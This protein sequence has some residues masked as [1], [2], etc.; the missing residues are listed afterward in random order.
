M[1]ITNRV[2]I[3]RP[4]PDVFAAWSE[5]ERIPEWYVDSIERRKMSEGPVGVGT[6]YHAV[7]KVPPG[8]RV[9]GTLEV[10]RFEPPSLMSASLSAPYNATWEVTFDEVE[11]STRMTMHVVADLSGIQALAAPLVSRWADR[12]QQRGLE[13]FK[14][15][16]ESS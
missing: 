7:D 11:G 15:D 8:R 5:L 16:L 14:T 6:T 4:M 10:T 13:A 3:D 12:V 9:E 2:V 1:E